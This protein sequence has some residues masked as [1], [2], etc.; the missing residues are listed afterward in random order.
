MLDAEGSLYMTSS[1]IEPK[2]RSALTESALHDLP[3]TVREVLGEFV[4]ALTEVIGPELEC[5]LLF[6][7]AA[8]GR[9]R[10]TSTWPCLQRNERI[11]MSAPVRFNEREESSSPTF[12]LSPGS[13]PFRHFGEL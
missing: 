5:V 9:L 6:G 7:S 10:P 13:K 2:E 8:E 11:E 3:A 12:T 1:D 4:Q